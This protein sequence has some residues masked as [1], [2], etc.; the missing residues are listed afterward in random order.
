MDTKAG[1][2]KTGADKIASPGLPKAAD[3]ILQKNK[4]MKRNQ[5]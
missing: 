5:R 1:S 3:Y 2:K 4:M